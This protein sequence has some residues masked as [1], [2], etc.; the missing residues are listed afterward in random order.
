MPAINQTIRQQ[1]TKTNMNDR[2]I[3]DQRIRPEVQNTGNK[4]GVKAKTNKQKKPL[5]QK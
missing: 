1:G 2:T 3:P 4:T 5:Q